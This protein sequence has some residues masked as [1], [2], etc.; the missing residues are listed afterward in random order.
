MLIRQYYYTFEMKRAEKVEF[1]V[2]A[3]I[4]RIDIWKSI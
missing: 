3:D 2:F 4:N 1:F